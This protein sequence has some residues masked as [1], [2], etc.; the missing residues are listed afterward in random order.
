MAC[1]IRPARSLALAAVAAAVLGGCNEGPRIEA[2]PQAITF[3]PAPT[4]AVNQATATVSATASS[5]L[6][7]V[8]SSRST[9]LCTVDETTG[10][11][12]AAGSGTCTIAASQ[13]GNAQYAAAFHVT[14]DVT[15]TFRGVITFGPAPSMNVF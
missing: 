15:F 6:P 5:G 10:L 4:P 11:V 8:Y 3:A 14:Q 2:R 7:V 12:T 1:P 9:P 13:P